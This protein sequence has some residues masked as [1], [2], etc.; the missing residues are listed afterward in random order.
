MT[1]TLRPGLP[2]EVGMLPSRIAYA[3][4]LCAGWVQQRQ[5]SLMTPMGSVGRMSDWGLERAC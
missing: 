5:E 4:D 2:E 1:T 3:R